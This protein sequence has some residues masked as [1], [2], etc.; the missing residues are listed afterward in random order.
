MFRW[1]ALAV[2]IGSLSIS[3]YYRR[4]A[5]LESEVI[6]RRREGGPVLA[7][8]ALAGLLALFSI[9]A[10]ILK[11]E[12]MTWATFQAPAW[13]PWAGLV[14]GMLV[15]PGVY[16]VFSSLG[17]NVSETVLTKQQHQLV[18]SGPYRWVRHPLYTTGLLMLTSVGMLLTSWLVLALAILA[19]V[20]VR[21]LVVPVEERMLLSKFGDEY[22]EYMRRT[23][24]FFP[25]LK[26][27][28]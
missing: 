17:R 23:A 3:G 25:G 4:R 8:R 14:L 9:L 21:V 24:R 2:L 26:S 20:L 27:A 13:V 18:V 28:R 22:A 19:L 15:I 5:R 12:W 6:P 1:L 7:A 16:W 11:P 10:H